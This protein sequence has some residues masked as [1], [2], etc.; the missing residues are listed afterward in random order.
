[1]FDVNYVSPLGA[2]FSIFASWYY[3]V[4]QD[5]RIL[6]SE[7]LGKLHFWLTFIGVNLA[8]FP[9]RLRGCRERRD[10]SPTIRMRSPA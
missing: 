10:A 2:V 8:F 3:W 9:M 1:M 4:S 7:A 6:V 5:H